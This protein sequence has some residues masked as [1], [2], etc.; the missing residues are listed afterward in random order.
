MSLSIVPTPIG[1]EKDW[2]LRAIDTLKQAD[3]IIVEEF[4]AGSTLLKSIGITGATMKNL[5]EHSEPEDI[6]ELLTDCKDKSVALITDCG[7]PS[8]SDPGYQLVKKCREQNIQITT[9]PGP[10]S[11]MTLISMSSQKLTEFVFVGFLPRETS[12]RAQKLNSLKS[13]K[14]SMIF[15]DTP[16][17]LNKLI[18]ELADIFADRKALLALNMTKDSEQVFEDKLSVIQKNLEK[19]KSEFM[20]LVY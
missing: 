2:T 16:Y 8:F 19:Q 20:L 14:R 11:L 7:T 12:E 9:L 18:D 5:N 1:N 6:E 3:L 4:R 17:R 13:E 10:S 15:M